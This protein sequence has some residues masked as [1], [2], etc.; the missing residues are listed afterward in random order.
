MGG[1]AVA[2]ELYNS[3]SIGNAGET[4]YGSLCDVR[5]GR[6]LP[7]SLARNLLMQGLHDTL[8]IAAGEPLTFRN[9][10]AAGLAPTAAHTATLVGVR[11]HEQALNEG[12]GSVYL[13]CFWKFS[14]WLTPSNYGSVAVLVC[15]FVR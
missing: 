15:P 9:M 10:A 11:K 14:N 7:H 8:E 12:Q 13:G 1:V 3:G 6:S 5:L 2:T 4:A